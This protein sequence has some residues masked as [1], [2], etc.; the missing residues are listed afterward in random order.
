MK[1]WITK[2]GYKI[3]RVLS[4]RSNVFLLSNGEKNILVDSGPSFMR[5]TL[6][7]RLKKLQITSINYLVLTHTHSDHCGNACSIKEKF[8]PDIF[9]HRNEASNLVSGEN[10]IP[11]GTKTISKLIANK[12]TRLIYHYIKNK[13]CIYNI[14]VDSEYDLKNLGFDAYI[15]HTPGHTPGSI[16]IIIDNEIALVGDTMFGVFKNSVFPPF[17]NDVKLM[18]KS[19]GKLLDTNCLYFLPSH[20]SANG[21]SLVQKEYDK[22]IREYLLDN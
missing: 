19:W 5:R 18:V 11:K 20:G 14:L 9:V 6:F 21:K 12:L 16:S 2:N 1:I 13:S 3:Y 8:H 4:G 17:A 22:K 15:L 10:I 7:R